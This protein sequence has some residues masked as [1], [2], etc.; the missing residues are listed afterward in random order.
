MPIP[1]ASAGAQHSSAQPRTHTGESIQE[2]RDITAQAHLQ[3]PKP[4]QPLR[5]AA[6]PNTGPLTTPGSLPFG[7][8]RGSCLIYLDPTCI[9]QPGKTRIFPTERELNK[10]GETM[11]SLYMNSNEHQC[12]A[13]GGLADIQRRMCKRAL[14]WPTWL[15]WPLCQQADATK[16]AHHIIRNY[17]IPDIR[18]PFNASPCFWDIRVY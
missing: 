12:C 8:G 10:T 4:A 15:C 7:A 9:W 5:N 2:Q 13:A 17:T 1:L 3:S 6:S 11:S 16:A 14:W 18:R